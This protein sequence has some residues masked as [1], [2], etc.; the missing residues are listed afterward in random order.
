[1]RRKTLITRHDLVAE[2]RV[3]LPSDLAPKKPTNYVI[4]D[5]ENDMLDLNRQEELL[6]FYKLLQG[7]DNIKDVI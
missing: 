2:Q 6:C 5:L 3:G 4:L 1:M 7:I